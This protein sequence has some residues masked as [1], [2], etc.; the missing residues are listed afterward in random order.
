MAVL[1]SCAVPHS[2]SHFRALPAHLPCFAL[3]EHF[4]SVS[5]LLSYFFSNPKNWNTNAN[6]ENLTVI[7][8][9]RSVKPPPLKEWSNTKLST[10]V[11][12]YICLHLWFCLREREVEFRKDISAKYYYVVVCLRI[13]VVIINSGWSEDMLIYDSI[14]L[15]F[16]RIIVR[17]NHISHSVSQSKF[18]VR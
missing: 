6:L 12:Q 3:W 13:Y 5:L 11:H 7:S 14:I 8:V 17:P 4:G 16:L 15:A 1:M 10:V 2:C 9:S 18:L